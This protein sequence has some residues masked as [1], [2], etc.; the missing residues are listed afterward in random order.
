VIHHS[1]NFFAKCK[2]LRE[3]GSCEHKKN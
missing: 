1:L 3:K 2:Q